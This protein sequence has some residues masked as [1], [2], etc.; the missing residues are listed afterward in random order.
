MRWT[1]VGSSRPSILLLESV[2]LVVCFVVENRPVS[3]ATPAAT[4]SSD[5]S[6]P[7]DW[8]LYSPD[9][10]HI[11]NRL[12]FSLYRR[13][14]EGKEYG[15]DELDPLLWPTTK[16]L[17]NQP[18]NGQ[19][20]AVLDEFLATH[21]ERAIADPVAR[22][23]MQ[24]DLWAIFDWTT[25]TQ[26]NT[27]EKLNLQN[28]LAVVIRRLSLS[29]DQIARL[30]NTYERTIAAKTFAPA[31]DANH[32]EQPFLPPDLL[33][34]KGPWVMVSARGGSPIAA[35]HVAA[36]SGR[37]VFFI[38]M[39]LPGGRDA[40]LDYLKK[41]SEFPRPWLLDPETRR[42]VPN[43]NLP[44]FPAGTQLALVRVIVLIDT[45]GNLEPTNIIE[46]IQIRVHHTIPSEIPAGLNL[47]RNEARR[48]MNVFEFKLSRALL[49]AGE[50]GGL[51]PILK[52]DTE[53]PLFMSHG[54]DLFE[55]NS[56][57]FPLGRML[58]VSLD[59]CASCHFRPGVH[60]ML[61]RSRT[62]LPLFPEATD[63]LQAWDLNFEAEATKAWKERQHNWGLLEG[64]WRSQIGKSN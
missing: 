64:L 44:E 19:A 7:D 26:G 54:I 4:A 17:L 20:I 60:S 3:T 48:A 32:P 23:I 63:V 42:A 50:S 12:Y 37:S 52:G 56:N 36:F 6:A 34:P 28:K 47:D 25:E 8:R 13:S 29:R 59:A 40:T 31:Y 22:A 33:R 1:K 53:F 57:G 62:Q 51:H 16:Y 38:F 49:L 46:D 5:T 43:P 45:E 21:A 27:P 55:T 39:H 61:S 30:P 18:A 2:F 58:R 9:A 10:S 11:W 14:S 35:T 41:L 24:R 15:Y